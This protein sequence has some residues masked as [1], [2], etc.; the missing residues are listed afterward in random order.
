MPDVFLLFEIAWDVF[1]FLQDIDDSAVLPFHLTDLAFFACDLF[2]FFDVNAVVSLALFEV[3]V[4]VGVES[5][6]ALR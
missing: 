3:D 6:H 2:D 5:A 4:A 1:W